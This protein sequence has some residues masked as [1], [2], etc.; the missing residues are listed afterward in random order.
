MTVTPVDTVQ[1]CSLC[2]LNPEMPPDVHGNMEQ[3]DEGKMNP[4]LK[5]LEP[6]SPGTGLETYQTAVSL[7]RGDVG[8]RTNHR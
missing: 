8:K 7:E 1:Y 5:E 3:K 2:S 4:E 6:P